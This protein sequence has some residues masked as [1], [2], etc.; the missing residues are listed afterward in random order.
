MIVSVIVQTLGIREAGGQ[1]SLELLKKYLQDSSRAPMLFVLDNFE[2]LMPAA[3]IV[4]D[5]L[6]MASKSQN[7]GHQPRGAARLR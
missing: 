7:P 4:A 1:S 2:H 3:P 6:A 5:F